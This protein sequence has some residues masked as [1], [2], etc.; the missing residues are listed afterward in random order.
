M[1]S[2][3]A[4]FREAD[5][6]TAELSRA[7]TRLIA[8]M[9]YAQDSQ[10]HLAR[11]VGSTLTTGGKID[12]LAQWSERIRQVSAADI[13]RVANRYLAPG[14]AVVGHLTKAAA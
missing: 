6:T 14:K 13:R 11:M 8:D 1:E 9:V 2:V 7:R 4:E 3:L 12:D 10:A 5:V